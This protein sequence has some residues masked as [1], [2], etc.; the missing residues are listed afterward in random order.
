MVGVRG[1]VGPDDVPRAP[2]G[3]IPRWVLDE[4]EARS[5]S[6]APR[7]RRAGR[8][9]VPRNSHQ[10]GSRLQRSGT[11]LSAGL[12]LI[13]AV[14]AGVLA[15]KSGRLPQAPQAFGDTRPVNT[16]IP[17]L[18]EADGP[19]GKPAPAG[20]SMAFQFTVKQADGS[21]PVGYDPC[22][23]IHY[24]TRFDGA[25]PGGRALIAAAVAKAGAA[26]GLRFID[27]GPITESASGQRAAYQPDR[28]GDRWAPV[29]FVWESANEQPD[30]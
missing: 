10:R 15:V 26:T 6:P 23:P 18:E 5:A 12:A 29:L 14:G 21:G 20:S 19:L 27:D 11:W 2:S 8:G 17:G 7:A 30:F 28:Y 4:H 1:P 25:P 24:V 13:V 16:P 22:R 3:R 9:R